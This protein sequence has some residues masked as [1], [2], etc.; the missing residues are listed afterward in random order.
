MYIDRVWS[1]RSVNIRCVVSGCICGLV[2]VMI[3]W[4]VR[5][6]WWV[7]EECDRTVC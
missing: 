4:R 3:G 5:V 2:G 7:T 6:Y 1:Q